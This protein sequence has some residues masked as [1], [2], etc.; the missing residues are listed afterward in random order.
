MRRPIAPP[1]P[2]NNKISNGNIIV[3][4]FLVFFETTKAGTNRPG[5]VKGVNRMGLAAR[6]TLLFIFVQ[7][8]APVAFVTDNIG[9]DPI[10]FP[11]AFLFSCFITFPF[12]EPF[13]MVMTCRKT[14][15]AIITWCG[16]HFLHPRRLWRL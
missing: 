11:G 8:P 12:A 1:N 14:I 5:Y 3:N 7:P 2:L 15:R 6:V 13:A 9:L 4:N 10:A 16:R